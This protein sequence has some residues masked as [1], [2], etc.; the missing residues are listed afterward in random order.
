MACLATIRWETSQQD[1]QHGH[2]VV[3]L[4][5]GATGFIGSAVI[6]QFAARDYRRVIGFV[7]TKRDA[8][9][10]AAAGVAAWIGDVSDV[11]SLRRVMAQVETVINCVSYVG[12]DEQRCIDVNQRGTQNIATISAEAGVDRLLYVSTAAVYGPGPFRD[13]PVDGVPIRPRSPAS[14]TRA[15]AEVYVRDAGGL[16]IR[17]HLVYGSGDK[18]FWPGLRQMTD[19]MGCTIDDGSALHSTIHV[20]HLAKII[21]DLSEKGPVDHGRTMHVNES[22]PSHVF[23]ILK[24]IGRATGWDVPRHSITRESALLRAEELGIDTKMINLISRDHWFRSSDDV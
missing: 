12:H 21:A 1:P 8:Q 7:R 2:T 9:E 17:P 10:L 6:R 14:R 4:V 22:R 15:A 11:D 3:T 24:Q 20:D 16:V 19:R 23:E 18:W 13:L 5:L